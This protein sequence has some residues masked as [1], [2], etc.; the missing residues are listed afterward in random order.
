M[1]IVVSGGTG[2][3]GNALLKRLVESGHRVTLLTRNPDAVKHPPGGRVDVERW[4]G[5]TAGSW[6]QCVDG[7][8]A[9]MN[10]AGEP[11]AAKRWTDTQKTRILNS[12]LDATR[13]IVAAIQKAEQKP[14]VLVNA[15]A[16]GYYGHVESGD[17]TESHPKGVDFL[18]D[19]CARW[20]EEVTKAE[21][22][23]VRVV[24]LRTGIV[25]E[26]D[27]GALKKMLL[28]FKL[29][30]G[31]SLGSG[32]QWFPWVHRDDVV[33]IILFVLEHADLSGPVNVAAP[34]PVT[35]KQFCKALGAVMGRPSWAPVPAFVLR[36]TLGEMS[37]MLLTGQRVVP[38]KLQ[39]AGYSFRYPRLDEALAAIVGKR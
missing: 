30:V 5:K 9:V 33:G 32:H 31:G 29:F 17:V 6:A 34:E 2:F 14:S 13:A 18:A 38:Q 8:D 1:N 35:M 37:D 15:S 28:P 22:L 36:V 25:L 12:R 4:D 16:V 21:P 7:A 23:G 11:I 26:K 27:G 24:R 20:E 3:I 19:T 39:E 10:M